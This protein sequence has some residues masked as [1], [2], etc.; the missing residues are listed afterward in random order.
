MST[1][2]RSIRIEE[3]EGYRSLPIAW[4]AKS[5]EPAAS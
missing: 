5:K 1:A 4:E 2:V 3:S